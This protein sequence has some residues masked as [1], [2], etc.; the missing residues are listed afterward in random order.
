MKQIK[1][2][3]KAGVRN[4]KQRKKQLASMRYSLSSNARDKFKDQLKKGNDDKY[5]G[6]DDF[7]TVI[8]RLC[9]LNYD[10]SYHDKRRTLNFIRKWKRDHSETI[11]YTR[12]VNKLDAGEFPKMF[13]GRADLTRFV[14]M[15]KRGQLK[16]KFEDNPEDFLDI[17][18]TVIEKLQKMVKV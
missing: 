9:F 14:S 4:A 7:E 6:L 15:I 2:D 1:A 8:L 18:Y 12:I 10:K 3:K 11:T 17:L 5:N 16:A 13:P